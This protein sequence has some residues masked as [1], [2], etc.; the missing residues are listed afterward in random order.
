METAP[1]SAKPGRSATSRQYTH[2]AFA[3]LTGLLLGFDLCVMG[4]LL[5]PVQR[6]LELCYPCAGGDTDAALAHCTCPAKGAAVS[7]ASVGAVFGALLASPVAD[8]CGRRAALALT[9]VCF[10]LG[11]AAMAC[12]TPGAGTLLFF[13]GRAA[14]GAGL[15]GGFSTVATYLAETAPAR[16]RGRFITAAELA[17]CVGCL[18][19]YVA[20]WAIGDAGWRVTMGL[21]ALPALLQLFGLRFVLCESPIWLAWQGVAGCGGVWQG[22]EEDVTDIRLAHLYS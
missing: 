4:S 7:L 12:A 8:L 15:G 18:A 9:D 6:S 16:L 5:T 19:A 21:A 17:V 3:S 1:L 11:A 20:A 22:V 10:A 14:V 13:A 2:L